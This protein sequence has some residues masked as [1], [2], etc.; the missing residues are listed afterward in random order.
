MALGPSRCGW[1]EVV[2]R[3]LV[4]GDEIGYEVSTALVTWELHC[5]RAASISIRSRTMAGVK[6]KRGFMLRCILSRTG[7]IG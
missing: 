2:R 4:P 6:V 3:S 1:R 7:V 5:L